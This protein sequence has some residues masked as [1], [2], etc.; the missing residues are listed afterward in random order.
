MSMTFELRTA[1]KEEII[2]LESGS[3]ETVDAF[4]S[5]NDVA[6]LDKTWDGIHVTLTGKRSGD[7]AGTME[8]EPFGTHTIDST[9]FGYGPGT[10]L[11]PEEVQAVTEHLVNITPEK[12]ASLVDA[13]ALKESEIYPFQSAEDNQ[14]IV[15]YLTENYTKMRSFYSAAA[16]HGHHIVAVLL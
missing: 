3:K 5:K 2:Q 6:S 11:T 7:G 14:T 12:F 13:D 8:H 9:D 16:E 4:M 10:Y 15:D 1:T